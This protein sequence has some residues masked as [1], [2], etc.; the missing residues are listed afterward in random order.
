MPDR[1]SAARA[2]TTVMPAKTTALP[3]VATDRRDRLAR[4]SPLQDVAAVPVDDE[5]GVVDADREPEHERERRCRLV[6]LDDR[7]GGHRPA[8]ADP[9]AEEGDE[10]R[11]AGGDEAAEDDD[12]HEHR[13]GEADDLAGTDEHDLLGDLDAVVRR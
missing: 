8:E 13:D 10:Q 4:S 2:M 9:H 12:E 6:E 1:T 5:Q 3:A 7:G 11:Q